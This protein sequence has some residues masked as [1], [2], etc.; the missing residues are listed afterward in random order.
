MRRLKNCLKCG[1]ELKGEWQIKFCSN[2]CAS[3]YNRKGKKHSEETKSLISKNRKGKYKGKNHHRWNNGSVIVSGYKYVSCPEHPNSTKAGYI[4]ESRFIMEKHIN[5]Y[6]TNNEIIHH[7]N[8]NTFDN[9]IENLEI[10]TKEEHS[11]LHALETSKKR[12]LIIKRKWAEGVYDKTNF[13][14]EF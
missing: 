8:K 13:H 7:K 2:K 11:T 5:R 6:L 3:S 14:P 10:L 1:K 12:S 9:R 4:L